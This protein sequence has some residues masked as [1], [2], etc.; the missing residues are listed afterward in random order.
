MQNE[1]NSQTEI[2]RYRVLGELWQHYRRILVHYPLVIVAATGVLIWF[3]PIAKIIDRYSYQSFK[4]DGEVAL[5]FGLPL[6]L[7]G[8]VL[9]AY[10]YVMRQA[11]FAIVKIEDE[12]SKIDASHGTAEFR[13]LVNT[14][15][16]RTESIVL[17]LLLV[18]AVLIAL[19]GMFMLLHMFV[20]LLAV[21]IFLIIG[22]LSTYE[23][24]ESSDK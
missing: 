19:V 23:N 14:N 10:C 5:S 2:A 24:K 18:L 20:L 22:T 17:L 13:E 9:L 3:L 1:I 15:G 12:M 7:I 16:P 21:I 11:R 6:T 8:L 4:Y